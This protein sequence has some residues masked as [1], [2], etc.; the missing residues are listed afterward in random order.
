MACWH[1]IE[2]NRKVRTYTP[3][4]FL[5]FA[6]LRA[7]ILQT[8]GKVQVYER[9]DAFSGGRRC[10]LHCLQTIWAA[11]FTPS[12][13]RTHANTWKLWH[14]Q[15]FCSPSLAAY[16]RMHL[17]YSDF[18]A[19]EFGNTIKFSFSLSKGM[20]AMRCLECSCG[21]A[22]GKARPADVIDKG[23]HCLLMLMLMLMLEPTLASL[24]VNVVN[25]SWTRC[26]LFLSLLT[27]IPTYYLVARPTQLI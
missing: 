11:L 27:Y 12:Q 20:H 22:V 2:T 23:S 24:P 17:T 21:S 3:S 5:D 15:S 4:P 9:R 8:Q 6:Q 18:G 7:E 14:P 16:Y 25:F 26:C 13:L 19:V 10:T 1:K